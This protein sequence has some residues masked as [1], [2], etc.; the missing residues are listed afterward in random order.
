ME[1]LKKGK[2]NHTLT[3]WL[4][5]GIFS[6]VMLAPLTAIAVKCMYVICNKNA[7]L[8]YADKTEQ[9]SYIQTT[10]NMV[11]NQFYYLHTPT[12]TNTITD[13]ITIY[14]T[15]A[16]LLSTS[17]N[18]VVDNFNICNNIRITTTGAVS[19]YQNSTYK[20]SFS[21]NASNQLTMKFRLTSV[22]T[23]ISTSGLIYEITETQQ[24]LDEVF[25]Y[26]VSEIENENIFNWTTTT[27][28]YTAINN[29]VTGL[30]INNNTISI[31]LTYWTLMVG[32]Y[33]VFDIIIWVFTKLTHFTQD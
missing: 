24:N 21:I 33:I 23:N 14:Y 6:I 32:I 11:E 4:K 10:N 27:G 29:M 22:T 5:F 28:I 16:E 13:A 3:D 30:G 1:K 2:H 31:L 15:D 7:Y 26:A 25:Y 17:M 12:E 8:N 19:L 18:Y 9:I 20:T